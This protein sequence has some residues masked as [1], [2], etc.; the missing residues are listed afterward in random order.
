MRQL[1]TIATV[2]FC[3]PFAAAAQPVTAEQA[4]LPQMQETIRQQQLQLQQQAEQIRAQ[5]EVLQRLQQQ[6]G[7]LQ[8]PPSGAPKTASTQAQL[9]SAPVVASGND[10]I[11][12]AISGQINRAVVVADDSYNT[13]LYQVDNAASN[14]RIRFVGSAKATDDLTVG[15]RIE[16][17]VSPDRSSAVSQQQKALSDTYFDQRWVD[18]SFASKTF[19]T[20]SIGKGDTASNN[21]AEVDL[22]RTDVV[23]YASI[24]DMG[25]GFLFRSKNGTKSFVPNG[26][27]SL[28]ISDAFNDLDGLSRQSRL[29][30]DSP[31]LFGFNLAGSLVSN[32][33]SDLALFWGGEGYGFK[34]AGAI[35]VANPKLT[36]AGLLYDGSFSLLHS[37]S[38]LNLTLSGATQEYT[39]RK[40]A[41]NLYAKL[42]W[43]TKLTSFGYTAFGVDYT[44]SE[45]MAQAGDKGN[46]VGA[47]MVQSFDKIATE[48]YF[49]YR[50]YSLDRAAGSPSV[51]NIN[52]GTIG[53]RVKF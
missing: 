3:L 14:S 29:R 15:A 36:N 53:A 16:I 28:K 5:S 6:I 2:L 19:G 41:I 39:K 50:V 4:V 7:S 10:R 43:L 33:R 51:A 45:H 26:S 44:R 21:S 42:G 24:S 18:L 22:S 40:D 46:S 8:L 48:L 25:G 17:A 37:A 1:C 9:T 27:S 11:K 30:Y 34:G 31:K 20:L 38:G 49:Q 12:L 32:Q 23:Q 35:A 13:T 52:I 47:A